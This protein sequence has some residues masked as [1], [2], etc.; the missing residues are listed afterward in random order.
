MVVWLGANRL[1]LLVA[2]VLKMNGCC[3]R[4]G[5]SLKIDKHNGR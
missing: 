2:E 4:R 3:L 5:Q 1:A